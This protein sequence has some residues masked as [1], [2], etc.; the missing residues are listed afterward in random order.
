[1]GQGVNIDQAS[2]NDGLLNHSTMQF[3]APV[4]AAE[5]VHKSI[6]G[7]G[8]RLGWKILQQ[9]GQKKVPGCQKGQKNVLDATETTISSAFILR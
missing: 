3:L 4:L 5:P 6:L 7:Q 9:F 8:N 2:T 1:M